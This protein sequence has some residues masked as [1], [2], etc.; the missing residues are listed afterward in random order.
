MRRSVVLAASLTLLASPVRAQLLPGWGLQ[1]HRATQADMHQLRMDAGR[2]VNAERKFMEVQQGAATI[3]SLEQQ[4]QLL[5]IESEGD[6]G[7]DAL[8]VREFWVK[9]ALQP[10]FDIM[11]NPAAT[12]ELARSMLGRIVKMEHQAQILGLAGLRFGDLG[13]SKSILGQAFSLARYRCLAEAFDECMATGTGQALIMAMSEWGRQIK[14][15]SPELEEAWERQVTY[16][17][18]RCT[19]YKLS[20]DMKLKDRKTRE[21]SAVLGSF[22]L[23]FQ[24]DQEGIVGF[25]RGIWRPRNQ[26]LASPDVRVVDADCGPDITTCRPKTR[27]GVGGAAYGIVL[28]RREAKE[29]SFEVVPGI[30]KPP[31]E[32]QRTEG[33]NIITDRRL[34]MPDNVPDA[35]TML[36]TTRHREGKDSLFMNFG[37]PLTQLQA[38]S[39]GIGGDVEMGDANG[40][41]LYYAANGKEFGEYPLAIDETW[42]RESYPKLYSAGHATSSN[43]VEE[44]TTFELTHR[45]DLF[46]KEDYVESLELGP[47][48]KA[49]QVPV[50]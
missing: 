41:G 28:M 19:V 33:P 7:K 21:S 23:L 14:I 18:R 6:L 13:D 46:P 30:P 44:S 11:A 42:V 43:G 40:S 12:C 4:K 17:F 25:S 27:G 29:Q 24:T 50:D 47:Q 49:P 2:L 45:P 48:P 36:H 8:N 32:T 37:P 35:W 1:Q 39:A 15:T 5:G 22:I 9:N 26:E 31:L 16:L 34:P 38:I 20:Y 10:A 3:L